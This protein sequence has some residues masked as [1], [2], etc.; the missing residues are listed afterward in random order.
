MKCYL[1]NVGVISTD[2]AIVIKQATVHFAT[3][4]DVVASCMKE[5]SEIGMEMICPKFRLATETKFFNGNEF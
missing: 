3:N 5:L 1:E 2:N 4:E